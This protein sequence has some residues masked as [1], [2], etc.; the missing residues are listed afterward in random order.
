MTNEKRDLPA[1]IAARLLNLA[2]RTGDDYHTLFTSYCFERFLYRLGRSPV[3]DR[4]VLK[5]AMLLRV[6]SDRPYRSTRD[7]D[8]LRLGDATPESILE[9]IRAICSAGVEADGIVFDV[10]A[11]T[12]EAIRPE[13]EYAGTRVILP[14]RCGSARFTLRIDLGVG[15]AVWPAAQPCAYPVL[16]DSPAPRILAYPR[17]AVVAEKFEAMVVLGDRNSRIRDFFDVHHLAMH[18]E[19]ERMTLSEA[20]GRT[21][22]QRRTPIPP[23]KPLALTPDYWRNPSRPAQVRAFARRAGLTL[24]DESWSGI[25]SVLD[26]FLSP[27]LEDLRRGTRARSVWS[28]GGPWR[29]EEHV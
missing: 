14:A 24:P 13:D 19:F 25:A 3:R 9:D 8:L 23:E 27:V 6:W 29:T 7:L 4:F 1:S 10:G 11:M 17:E 2:K 5:G 18:F 26:A 12:T 20:V 21:F 22:A 16:L 28:P 15:D